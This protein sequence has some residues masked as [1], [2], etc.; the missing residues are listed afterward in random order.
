MDVQLLTQADFTLDKCGR[1]RPPRRGL[2]SLF[3]RKSF[4]IQ[5]TFA[6]ATS[7]P[8]QTVTKEITGESLWHLRGLQI[9]SNPNTAL[10][11]QILLPNGRFLI[12]QLQDALQ[13]AGYGSYRYTFNPSL[14]CPPGTKVSITFEVTNTT[15]QQPMSIELSG[16][17][18]Y[19]LK[20]G[21]N[22]ICPTDEAAENLP[23]YFGDPNQN[24]M[25]PA[26]QH[27]VV[28]PPPPG[29]HDEDFTYS[30]LQAPTVAFPAGYPGSAILVTATNLTATQ[31][32]T[33]DAA[34]FHC[35]RLVVQ[36]TE[37]NTVTA[38]SVLVRIRL[39]SGQAVFDDY[40]DAARYVGSTYWPIDLVIKANDIVYAD[41][42]VV[43]QAGS[44]N[45]YWTMFLEGFKRR[46][47]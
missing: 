31:Q 13:I 40:L 10:S 4:L 45:I 18:E 43:D 14:K 24:I 3:I 32:I 36:V 6:A 23:R 37:D 17:Y 33:M 46:R 38:G 9:T 42:Q 30:A 11:L 27:G 28:D 34:E 20:G 29:Y 15:N 1:P 26:W 16:A 21:D 7:S 35:K 39:G 25:A 8:T 12:N 2:S 47:K 44:G 5:T 41:L 22:R 19:L